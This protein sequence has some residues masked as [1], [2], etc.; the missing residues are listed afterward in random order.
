M[1]F[2]NKKLMIILLYILLVSTLYLTSTTITK[3]STYRRGVATF[4]IGQKLYFHYERG[5]LFRNNNLIIGVEMEEPIY[6]ENGNL[7]DIQRRIETMNVTPGDNLTYHFY[8]S[9]YNLTTLE[10]NGVDGSFYISAVAEF[11]MP[12]QKSNYKLNCTLSY[13]EVSQE[14][15]V[16]PFKNFTSDKELDLPIYVEDDFATHMNYEFEI[17]VILDE[18]IKTTSADD[19]VDATL[20]ILLF[21]DATNDIVVP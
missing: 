15:D 17:Y 21:I 18:Q 1:K 6:D 4:N 7:T 16:K 20:S 2:T 5:D 8:V 19:Y 13:R 12:S 3:Y 9:N 10:R 14:G 11:S